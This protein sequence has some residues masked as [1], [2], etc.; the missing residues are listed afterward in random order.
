[1][2]KRRKQRRS[3]A[4]SIQTQQATLDELAVKRKE[5]Q[6]SK[7][8]PRELNVLEV[9]DTLRAPG[10]GEYEVIAKQK[11]GSLKLQP[12]EPTN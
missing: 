5:L 10:Y 1:M 2:A 12:I 8:E 11:N 4:K 6:Q 9:G 7:P 3:H